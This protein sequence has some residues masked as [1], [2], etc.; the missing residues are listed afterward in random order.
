MQRLVHASFL[1]SVETSGALSIES[2]PVEEVKVLDLKTPGS[3]E[4]RR[5]LWWN[6]AQLNPQDQIKFVLCSRAD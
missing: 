4:Y 1:V 6:L 5:N 3:Q 2:V